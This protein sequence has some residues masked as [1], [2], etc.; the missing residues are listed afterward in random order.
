MPPTHGRG[1][2]SGGRRSCRRRVRR[3]TLEHQGW[4]G[5]R[6]TVY[7]HPAETSG[8]L[9]GGQNRRQDICQGKAKDPKPKG[10]SLCPSPEGCFRLWVERPSMY[11]ERIWTGRVISIPRELVITVSSPSHPSFVPSSSAVLS[12]TRTTAG[13]TETDWTAIHR[14]LP[15]RSM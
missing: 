8:P 4:K 2:A 12:R 15:T 10:A 7:E 14:P 13:S 3:P 6:Q 1:L 5:P 11:S 9:I